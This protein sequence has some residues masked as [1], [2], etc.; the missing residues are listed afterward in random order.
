MGF[1]EEDGEEFHQVK[2]AL[3]PVV[4]L[5][6]PDEFGVGGHVVAS[7][8]ATVPPA[9]ELHPDV[10]S[11]E[12]VRVRGRGMRRRGVGAARV[13]CGGGSPET[14]RSPWVGGG[15]DGGDRGAETEGSLPPWARTSQLSPRTLG[16]GIS[17]VGEDGV[18]VV[19]RG[20]RC[21]ERV[22]SAIVGVGAGST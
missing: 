2:V 8:H 14:L 19:V 7:D 16:V 10:S 13:F 22:R 12:V 3:V 1:G 15:C 21:E 11:D 17:R 20:S 4:E 5:D 18:G 9:A 6:V